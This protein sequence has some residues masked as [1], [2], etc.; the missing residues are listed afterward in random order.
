[1]WIFKGHGRRISQ[2]IGLSNCILRGVVAPRGVNFSDIFILSKFTRGIRTYATMDKLNRTMSKEAPLQYQTIH[3]IQ[4]IQISHCTP[5]G[6]KNLPL[7]QQHE[8]RPVSYSEYQIISRPSDET[9]LKSASS[10]F[11]WRGHTQHSSI[12]DS[13]KEERDSYVL[14]S[15]QEAWVDFEHYLIFVPLLRER[16]LFPFLD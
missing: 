9:R 10:S 8:F 5:I 13:L 16:I 15:R 3:T 11:R 1:M 14:N 6:P 7:L 4:T 2:W 12:P